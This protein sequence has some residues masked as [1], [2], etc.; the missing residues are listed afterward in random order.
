MVHAPK[1]HNNALNN[2][3]FNLLV[4]N[5]LQVVVPIGANLENATLTG[6]NMS[7]SHLDNASL[8]GAV[9]TDGTKCKSGSIGECKK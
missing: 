8:T 3:A 7:E 1:S 4:F 9:W 5:D 6:A 2:F